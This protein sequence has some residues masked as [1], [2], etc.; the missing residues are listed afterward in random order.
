MCFCIK[1]QLRWTGKQATFDRTFSNSFVEY[2]WCAFASYP[3]CFSSK[4]FIGH[5]LIIIILLT[6][7]NRKKKKKK[8]PEEKKTRLFSFGVPDKFIFFFC[9]TQIYNRVELVGFSIVRTILLPQYFKCNYFN[10]VYTSYT[11]S[12][13]YT[14][15][16]IIICFDG[17]SMSSFFFPQLIL[18]AREKMYKILH[19]THALCNKHQN[20]P[21]L[22]VHDY[23]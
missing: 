7:V 6:C 20:L 12:L 10:T 2:N 13:W 5:T 3:R 17:K 23:T 21:F 1:F 19:K 11:F 22:T 9:S 4:I 14:V 8:K 18:R 15:T 16:V